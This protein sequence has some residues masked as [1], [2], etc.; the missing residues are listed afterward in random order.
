MHF[1]GPALVSSPEMASEDDVDAYFQECGLD[2]SEASD[3]D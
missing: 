3:V 1:F 2:N